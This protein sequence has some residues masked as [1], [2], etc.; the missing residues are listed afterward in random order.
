[1]AERVARIGRTNG[2]LTPDGRERFI[3]IREGKEGFG[4]VLAA[5]KYRPSS[6]SSVE[7]AELLIADNVRTL[8]ADGRTIVEE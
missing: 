2:K 7:A 4:E 8:K 6:K 3:K 5:V 1:M